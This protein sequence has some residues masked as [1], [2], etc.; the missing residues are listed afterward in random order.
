MQDGV[1]QVGRAKN[2]H[3]H[4]R[5]ENAEMS[6]FLPKVAMVP[7]QTMRRKGVSAEARGEEALLSRSRPAHF[8]LDLQSSQDDWV[9]P[10]HEKSPAEK[11]QLKNVV[12]THPHD[13]RFCRGCVRLC[14]AVW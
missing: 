13:T 5:P 14:D 8:C 2:P 4:S 7:T 6:S 1:S 10:V 9:P 3:S 11:K 12:Q